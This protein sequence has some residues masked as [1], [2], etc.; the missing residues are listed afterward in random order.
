M[1]ALPSGPVASAR[2]VVV[3][4]AQRVGTPSEVLDTVVAD[5]R[6]RLR[7]V[8]VQSSEYCELVEALEGLEQV[9]GSPGYRLPVATSIE[10]AAREPRCGEMRRRR[11]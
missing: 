2:T 8:S 5:I 10:G 4:D 9:C 11:G 3:S 7:V 1:A 6:A